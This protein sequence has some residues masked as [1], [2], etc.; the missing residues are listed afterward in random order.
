MINFR[1]LGRAAV[2]ATLTYSWA[3]ADSS[4]VPAW[5][6]PLPGTAAFLGDDGG[7]ANTAT[8]CDS[9]AHFEEWVNGG[10][11]PGCV[12]FPRG[13]GVI[14]EGIVLDPP[15]TS[16]TDTTIYPLVRIRIPSEDFTGYVQL[17]G[18]IHPMIPGGTII[19]LQQSG[20]GTLELAS[21]QDADEDSGLNLGDHATAEVLRYD[22][23]TEYR[24]LY[25]KILDGNSAGSRGWVFTLD[26]NGADG[27]PLDAFAGAVIDGHPP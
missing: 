1:I 11:P 27:D 18:G 17:L 7:G 14:I 19:H 6:E 16:P 15:G 5:N 9:D 13:L 26:G 8:V 4:D 12:S 22:P 10:S 25:V 3:I 23:S 20:S 2:I 21:S 24:N